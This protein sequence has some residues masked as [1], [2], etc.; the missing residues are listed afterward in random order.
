MNPQFTNPDSWAGGSIDALMFFGQSP[1]EKAIAAAK[2]LWSIDRLDGPYRDRTVEPSGQ[3]RC[4]F[5]RFTTDGCEQLTGVMTHDDGTTSPFVHTTIFDDDGLW[6]YAGPPMGGLPDHWNVGAYPVDDGK[7]T[8]W[9]EPLL[10]SLQSLSHEVH[11]ICPVRAAV[12]GWLDLA[13]P[14]RILEA[15]SGKIPDER[16]HGLT[17]WDGDACTYFPPTRTEPPMQI[18]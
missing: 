13:E 4:G 6:V 2:A 8:A 10:D 18:A 5:D 17:L 12:Y 3:D 14:D 15:L 11:K 9:L 1:V 16:W 7:P